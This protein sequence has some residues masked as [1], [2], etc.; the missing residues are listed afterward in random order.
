MQADFS[1][2]VVLL[3]FILAIVLVGVKITVSTLVLNEFRKNREHK[4]LVPVALLFYMLAISRIILIYLDFFITG[5]DPILLQQNSYIWKLAM[6]FLNIG[7]VF[8]FY[9]GEKEIFLDKTKNLIT[10]SSIVLLVVIYFIPDFNLYQNLITI[11]LSIIYLFIPIGYLYIAKKTTGTTRKKAI[12]I[13]IGIFMYMFCMIMLNE[14]L[15]TIIANNMG[16]PLILL[17]FIMYSFSMI[18]RVAALMFV[19]YGYLKEY[20]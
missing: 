8:F 13:V 5:L 6:T 16:V 15:L 19:V 2:I 20:N 9:V 12:A 18:I 7:Y 17:T 1:N 11:S 10:I 3:A 4:L 14:G